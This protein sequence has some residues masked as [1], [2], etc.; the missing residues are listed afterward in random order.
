MEKGEGNVMTKFDYNAFTKSFKKIAKAINQDNYTYSNEVLYAACD[1][2]NV[3]PL[4]LSDKVAESMQNGQDPDGATKEQ[5]D[6]FTSMLLLIGRAYAASP[7]RRRGAKTI[8]DGM[9]TFFRRL[10]KEIV[11][12]RERYGKWYCLVKKL[13]AQ[14]YTLDKSSDDTDMLRH[15]I[16][17]VCELNSMIRI[18][19]EGID[20]LT[21]LSLATNCVSFCSKFLHFTAPNAFFIMDRLS[22][23]GAKA[24]FKGKVAEV[25]RLSYKGD[26]IELHE[27]E[28]K[29][30]KNTH[31]VFQKDL[32]DYIASEGTSKVKTAHKEYFEHCFRVYSVACL[33]KEITPISQTNKFHGN[34]K[35]C[36]MPRLVDS[37]VMRIKIKKE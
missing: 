18:A 35:L 33:I 13:S 32:P 5:L 19:I 4:P 34:T 9:D 16:W 15:S 22:C 3:L 21:N 25:T 8:N 23:E 11:M 1:G 26:L 12:Q 7:E 27:A 6:R 28:R 2:I 30:F 29:E 31:G 14:S 20:H 10:A 17:C 24:L 37:I 36:S